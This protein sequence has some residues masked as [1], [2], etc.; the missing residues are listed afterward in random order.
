MRWHIVCQH[1]FPPP[2][3]IRMS[4]NRVLIDSSS[5]MHI[6]EALEA[7]DTDRG[8]TPVRARR[9]SPRVEG[10]AD[11]GKRTER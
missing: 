7:R 2:N 6:I 4:H 9:G 3:I 1:D 8:G 11:Y 5:G 10:H